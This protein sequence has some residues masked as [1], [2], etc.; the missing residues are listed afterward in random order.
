MQSG[1]SKCCSI[2]AKVISHRSPPPPT[3]QSSIEDFL[4]AQGNPATAAAYE[5]G[6]GHFRHYLEDELGISLQDSP[7]PF[8][9]TL[10]SGVIK[11]VRGLRDKGSPLALATQQNYVTAVV[12]Y[13]IHVNLYVDEVEINT[14]KLRTIVRKEGPKRVR[15]SWRRIIDFSYSFID[16]IGALVSCLAQE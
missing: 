14:D 7:A 4:D 16:L 1:C 12:Q 5:T 13:L 8:D 3:I 10:I 2:T 6:L 9:H 11:Y 15:A